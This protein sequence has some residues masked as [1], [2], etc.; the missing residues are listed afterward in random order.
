MSDYSV[1][2]FLMEHD[3][4]VRDLDVMENAI[5]DM[6]TLLQ[7][8]RGI[9][10]ERADAFVRGIADKETVDPLVNT[11]VRQSNGDRVEKKIRMSKIIDTVKKNEMPFSPSMTAYVPK[12]VTESILSKNTLKNIALRKTFK[13]DKEIAGIEGDKVRYGI[14]ENK[15]QGRKRSNN[16]LSGAQVSVSTVLNNPTAHSTL[17]S[18]CSMT[19]GTGNANNE[20]FIV[21]NRHYLSPNTVLQNIA[22]IIN[23]TN[24]ELFE[25]AMAFYNIA[26]PTVE[27]CWQM[28]Y[29]SSK[30]YWDVDNLET[31]IPAVLA[32]LDGTER[33]MIMY[34]GDMKHLAQLNKELV[35]EMISSMGRLPEEPLTPEQCKEVEPFIK[36]DLW[37]LTNYIAK[38]HVN[39]RK[40]EEVMKDPVAYGYYCGAAKNTLDAISK[41]ALLIRAFWTT[42]N[43]PADV[44]DVP[45]IIRK[46]VPASDTDSTIFTVQSWVEM[47]GDG[48]HFSPKSEAIRDVVVYLCSQSIIHVLAMMSVNIGVADE[49]RSLLSMKNEYTFPVFCVTNATKHY[50]AWQGAVEGIV[51]KEMALELKGVNLKAT[52]SPQELVETCHNMIKEVMDSAMNGDGMVM[53]ELLK[54]IADIE[55][56]IIESIRTGRAKFLKRVNINSAEGYKQGLDAPAQKAHALWNTVFGP[57]YQMAPEPPYRSFRFNMNVDNKTAMTE[58]LKDFTNQDCKKRLEDYLEESGKN[59][60]KTLC[61][62]E[63]IVTEY[64]VPEDIMQNMDI[65]KTISNNMSCFYVMLSALGVLFL[66]KKNTNLISDYY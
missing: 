5:T 44:S 15:Q 24:R 32:G 9:T 11:L 27:D 35:G 34:I 29:D 4:Y 51:K 42:R 26:I 62:P 40:H 19:A 59:M 43:S 66:D 54:R 10:K 63:A 48:D 22:S 37:V 46:A 31:E 65:R 25:E 49:H 13:K 12:K 3:E 14:A 38:K 50:Y 47:Y 52:T 58:W 60:V 41:Y 61:I 8:A 21:G 33:A 55:R 2:P 53:S 45:T 36:G 16:S 28:I 56:E 6:S 18:T 57:S 23:I 39:F 17:T 64:G 7:K 1:N 30:Y 20:K